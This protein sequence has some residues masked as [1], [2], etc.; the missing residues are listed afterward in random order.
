LPKNPNI[1]ISFLSI[2]D[3]GALLQTY[4][5]NFTAWWN[6]YK[7]STWNKDLIQRDYKFL[8]KIL[9][10]CVKGVAEWMKKVNYTGER[11]ST[12]KILN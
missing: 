2:K 10:A 6:L 8:D 11:L 4:G 12:L 9:P 3:N 7:A 1:K 5:E